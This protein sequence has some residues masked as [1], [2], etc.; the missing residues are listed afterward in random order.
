[1]TTSF[2]PTVFLACCLLASLARG[3]Y[4]EDSLR[5]TVRIHRGSVSGTGF[6]IALQDAPEAGPKHLLVTAA[7]VFNH[8]QGETC[9]VSFRVP[10]PE[11]GFARKN[12]D[13]KI[14][15]GKDPRWVQHA[16]VDVA[17]IPVEPPAGVDLLPLPEEHITDEKFAADRRV[18]VGQEVC[19]P[20]FPAKVE[21]NGAGW[22]VCRRGSIAS[23]PLLPLAAAKTIFIDY[24]HFGGDSGAPVFA[25]IDGRPHAVALVIA[26]Q[27]QTD[28]TVSP[29]EERLVHTPLHLAI[30]VQAPLIRQ[31]IDEWRK[32][33]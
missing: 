6:V 2:R 33:K 31:T 10:D 28:K 3:D 16:E 21:A 30:A 1:M 20:C 19:I 9:E 24:S 13:V 22:P 32:R 18:R 4:F 23:H 26:M 5:A 14:R 8:L 25:E 29:F 11:R 12:L 7:H 27:R 17:V 15:E